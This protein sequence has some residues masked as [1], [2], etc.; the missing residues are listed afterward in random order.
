[1]SKQTFIK[2][3]LTPLEELEN[4]RWYLPDLG[5]LLFSLLLSFLSVKLY[6]ENQELKVEQLEQD[7]TAHRAAYKQIKGEVMQF[8]DLSE[9]IAKLESKKNSLLR[10]TDSKLL[11][12]LPVILIE[13]LQNLK[14]KGMWFTNVSFLE[15]ALVKANASTN[16]DRSS[17]SMQKSKKKKDDL[18]ENK[19]ENILMSVEGSAFNKIIIAEFMT[20]LKATENQTLDTRDVR[21]QVYFD[22]V[23]IAFAE[24]STLERQDSG[25]VNISDFKLILSFKERDREASLAPQLGINGSNKEDSVVK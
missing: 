20:A 9:K 11:R 24:M 21:T 1:M 22:G 2:I 16:A 3:N 23:K 8:D 12:Y 25:G 14:P 15:G 7:M 13:N 10:I 18:P 4:P 6:L 17:S 5:I 19:S